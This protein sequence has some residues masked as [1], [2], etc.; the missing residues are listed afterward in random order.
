MA[1]YKVRYNSKPMCNYE[2]INA[3]IYCFYDILNEN[4]DLL[5]YDEAAL[6]FNMNANNTSFIEYIKLIS[7]L[8]DH[9]ENNND[10]EAEVF[11]PLTMNKACK[12]I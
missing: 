11:V 4:Y 2:F 10:S 1:T 8:P 7:A 5:T 9:W 12:G 3:G 6:K